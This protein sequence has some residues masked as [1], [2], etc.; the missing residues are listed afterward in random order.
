MISFKSWFSRLRRAISR[1]LVPGFYRLEHE[2]RVYA[3][4]VLMFFLLTNLSDFSTVFDCFKDLIFVGW[5][6]FYFV[7]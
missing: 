6:V 2:A 4:L 1:L 7:A 5:V 3:V